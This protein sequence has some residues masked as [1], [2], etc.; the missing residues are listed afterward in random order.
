MIEEFG[1][2]DGVPCLY[3]HGTNSGPAEAALLGDAAQHRGVR[4]ISVP[5]PEPV[6]HRPPRNTHWS[7]G[8]A[9]WA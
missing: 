5:R 3:F 6:A 8:V 9:G 2:A 1:A 4:L 7:P